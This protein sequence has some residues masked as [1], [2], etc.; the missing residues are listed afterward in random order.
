MLF[1]IKI[2]VSPSPNHQTGGST[3]VSCQLSAIAYSIHLVGYD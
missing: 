3:P 1:Y 2:L